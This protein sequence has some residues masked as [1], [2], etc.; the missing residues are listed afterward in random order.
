[1]DMV[2]CVF[3]FK[4]IWQNNLPIRDSVPNIRQSKYIKDNIK[5]T[6]FTSNN[7]MGSYQQKY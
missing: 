7:G 2:G 5:T 6:N 1:M 4:N 3:Q